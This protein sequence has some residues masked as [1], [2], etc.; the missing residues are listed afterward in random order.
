MEELRDYGLENL[1]RAMKKI[2][3]KIKVAKL[4]S[5]SDVKITTLRQR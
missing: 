4:Y 5:D 3:I 1:N 2:Y